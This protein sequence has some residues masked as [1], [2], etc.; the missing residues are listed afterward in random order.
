MFATSCLRQWFSNMNKPW[1][2][3]EAL[4][5]QIADSCLVICISKRPFEDCWSEG[6]ILRCEWTSES[7]EKLA[8]RAP[9]RQMPCAPSADAIALGRGLGILT[10]K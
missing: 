3:L 2:H 7:P 1:N 9:P 5:K 10:W 8:N 6:M 4:L